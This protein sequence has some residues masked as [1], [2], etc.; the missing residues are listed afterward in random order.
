LGY[1]F[2]AGVTDGPGVPDFTQGLNKSQPDVGFIWPIISGILRTPT[3]KQRA[4]QL[5]KPI[6]LDIGGITLPYAWGPNLMDVQLMRIGPVIIVSN[7]YSVDF[8]GTDGYI[9]PS[10]R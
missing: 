5:P 10:T 9:D 7:L 8:L 4:C 6:F 3:E 1:R 2:A